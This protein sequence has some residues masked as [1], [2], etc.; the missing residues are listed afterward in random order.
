MDLLPFL[1]RNL[2]LE[3]VLVG[4]VLAISAAAES[5]VLLFGVFSSVFFVL[6]VIGYFNGQLSLWFHLILGDEEMW[7]ES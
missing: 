6:L 7:G 1:K 4:L 3:M 5:Q 2:Y